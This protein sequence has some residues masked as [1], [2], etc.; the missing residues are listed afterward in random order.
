MPPM[1]GSIKT[2]C[3]R[4]NIDGVTCPTKDQVTAVM[5]AVARGDLSW[6]AYPFSSFLE[7]GNPFVVNY[8]IEW[9]HKLDDF[10]KKKRKRSMNISDVPGTSKAL[11]PLLEKN[12][13]DFLSIGTNVRSALRDRCAFFREGSLVSTKNTVLPA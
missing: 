12:S 11:I 4:M 5:D 10:F 1:A 7:F 8:G 13:V 6:H 2:G 3:E 9:M